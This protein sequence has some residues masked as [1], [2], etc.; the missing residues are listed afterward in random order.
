MV[1]QEPFLFNTTVEENIAYG[2]P[3]C[4]EA[5]VHRAAEQAGAADFIAALPDGYETIVG[6]RGVKLSVG[7]KQRISIARALLKD[8][9]ILIL[10]EA[11][12]SVDTVTE[13]VIQDALATAA[14]G[15]TTILIAH[16]LSTTDIA[17]RIVVLDGGQLTEEGTQ[18]E[19]LARGGRFAELWEMQSLEGTVEGGAAAETD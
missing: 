13:R 6:E 3:D 1:L 7:Q 16:R 8:P 4:S 14:E 18:D 10:D 5:D 12:S 11:T 9:S 2:R 17:D 15:R 19:L